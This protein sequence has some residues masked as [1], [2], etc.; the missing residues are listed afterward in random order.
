[1]LSSYNDN[2]LLKK[3]HPRGDTKQEWSKKFQ[4]QQLSIAETDLPMTAAPVAAA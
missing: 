4:K 2:V 1:M 3:S